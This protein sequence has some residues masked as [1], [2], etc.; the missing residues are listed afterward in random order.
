VTFGPVPD[1]W[2]CPRRSRG[3]IPTW[4][5]GGDGS[6]SSLPLASTSSPSPGE[7]RRHHLHET[8][9]QRAVHRAIREAGLA[10]PATCHTFRHSFA[11]NLLEG[12]DDI[13]TVQDLRLPH[14]AR[15]ASL[16]HARRPSEVTRASGRRRDAPRGITLRWRS[17]RGCYAELSNMRWARGDQS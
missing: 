3:S 5:A 8:V 13:R 1:G 6:G 12:G 2:S 17:A 16:R 11:T 9:I 4:A 14:N 7:R 15:A 10:K